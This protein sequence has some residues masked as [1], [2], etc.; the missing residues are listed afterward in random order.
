MTL[1]MHPNDRMFS[2][3]AKSPSG[4]TVE[5]GTGGYLIKDEQAW[6]SATYD[7]ISLWGHRPPQMVA[8]ALTA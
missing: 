4:F 8:D 3:Y 1:G 6:E 2:F 7:S 5:Y